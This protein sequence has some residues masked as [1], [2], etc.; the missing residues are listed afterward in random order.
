MAGQ[1]LTRIAF[2]GGGMGH[3][4]VH[5]TTAWTVAAVRSD[6]CR[7]RKDLNLVPSRRPA[8]HAIVFGVAALAATMA[9]AG[10]R[11]HA[12][13]KLEARYSATLGGMSFGK[14]AWTIDVRD[15]QFTAA[16][17]GATSGVLR[18]FA[19]GQGTSAARGSVSNGQL[20]ASSYASSIHTE[21][22]YDEVR[23]V[24]NGGT[25]KE[26][27]AEPPVLPSPDR[28][29]ITDAHR[30]G[31]LDPMTAS[32]IRVPGNGG[33]FSPEA[34]QRKLAIFDGRMRYDLTFAFKRL[35]KVKS[36]KGYQGTVVVCAV[37][38]SPVA[39]HVP[40]RPVIKYLVDLREAEVWLA[41]IAG[42]RLMVPYR[43]SVPTPFGVGLLQATQFISEPYPQ[44][45]SANGVRSQ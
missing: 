8:R 19:S 15:D 1:K 10:S 6:P 28:V 39:G 23:M 41:P 37:Y 16:I 18:L 20:V 27:V 35:D 5:K 12:Q 17:S 24:L 9:D 2:P 36:E 21:T 14:G 34:C 30:R 45:A 4:S 26:Y 29:P 42:T 25:V 43:I 40:E 32:L 3:L 22:K 11:A 44:R 33:T 7:Q 31:V 38:F 13:G